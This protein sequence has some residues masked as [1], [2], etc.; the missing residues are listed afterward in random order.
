MDNTTLIFSISDLAKSYKTDFKKM[1]DKQFRLFTKMFFAFTQSFFPMDKESTVIDR[2]NKIF[3][4]QATRIE[5]KDS[6]FVPI[7]HDAVSIWFCLCACYI[8]EMDSINLGGKILDK[9]K[10][11]KLDLWSKVNLTNSYSFWKQM[12]SIV[13]I[14]G[15]YDDSIWKYP[16][17]RYAKSNKKYFKNRGINVY[18]DD[19]IIPTMSKISYFFVMG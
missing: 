16:D 19:D 18:S 12:I 15:F 9:F 1:S 5:L 3:S 7:W 11:T 2:K 6:P 17:R 10:K 4:G 13:R 14:H 8:A